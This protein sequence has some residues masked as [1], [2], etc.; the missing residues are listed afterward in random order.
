MIEIRD[1][2]QIVTPEDKLRALQEHFVAFGEAVK[3][4]FTQPEDKKVE[5]PP[6]IQQYLEPLKQENAELRSQLETL[7]NA[8]AALQIAPVVPAT[9][10]VTPVSIVPP[11]RSYVASPVQAGPKK[12]DKK[13]LSVHQIVRRNMG[14]PIDG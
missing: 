1:S 9:R 3:K 2:P 8:V 5:E 4:L 13:L 10:T 6:E 14:L 7:K 12:P 11:R